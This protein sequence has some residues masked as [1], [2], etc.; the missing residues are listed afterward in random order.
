MPA[1]RFA[2]SD[3]RM[4][5]VVEPGAVEMWVGAHAAA[6]GPA[7]ADDAQAAHV[8]PGAATDRTR[9]EL[10]GPVHEVTPADTR[11]VAVRIG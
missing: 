3:R 11:I 8:V 6:G 1:A 4:V 9:V 5:R 2:F 10:T 7:A